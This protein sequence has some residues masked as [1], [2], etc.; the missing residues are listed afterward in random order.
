MG[1]P[2]QKV[3]NWASEIVYGLSLIE[4][5]IQ[6]LEKRVDELEETIEIL[7]DPETIKEIK[8]ALKDLKAGRFKLYDDID[9]YMAELGS[10]PW[11]ITL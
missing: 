1:S 2:S 6:E 10:S 7:S 8:K 9:V 3:L 5:R 4:K 11:N